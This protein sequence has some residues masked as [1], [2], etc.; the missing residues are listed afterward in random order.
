[1]SFTSHSSLLV[2]PPP[3]YQASNLEKTS[4]FQ[5][6]KSSRPSLPRRR[7]TL[8]NIPIISLD[9]PKPLPS[10]STPSLLSRLTTSLSGLSRRSQS[11]DRT[12]PHN[13]LRKPR[14]LSDYYHRLSL[15][16]E[17]A[18]LTPWSDDDDDDD[19]QANQARDEAGSNLT[20]Q[21]P[22]TP[23]RAFVTRT[24]VHF[25]TGQSEVVEVRTVWSDGSEVITRPARQEPIPSRLSPQDWTGWPS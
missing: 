1:M 17:S 21:T 14:P 18:V 4:D 3:P 16:C 25:F 20:S 5:P 6:L 23:L 15:A 11:V 7:V 24:P 10:S 9:S 13:K 19:R 12:K 2:S 8:P 22:L